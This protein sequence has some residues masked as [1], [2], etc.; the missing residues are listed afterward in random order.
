MKRMLSLLVLS[1]VLICSGCKAETDPEQTLPQTT[2]RQ[3]TPETTEPVLSPGAEAN[4][5]YIQTYASVLETYAQ[6]L[7]ERW[8]QAQCAEAGISILTAY[9]TTGENPLHNLCFAFHDL[10]AD[11]D[12]ELLIAPTFYDGFVDEMV[13][14]MYDMVD[15]AP[16]LLFNGAERI[17][18][19]LCCDE[20]GDWW[21]ANEASGG[22]G[23]SGWFY[24]RYDGAGLSVETSVIYD[25][26]SAP[27]APW[28]LGTDDSWDLNVKEAVEEAAAW[29]MIA[30][31]DAWKTNVHRGFPTQQT[32]F[33]L[34]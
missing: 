6:A 22:A 32:F 14:A 16:R 30:S 17:R 20:N 8:N 15:G 34:K 9:C 10:D 4:S 18:Y 12:S 23:Y 19:Y 7:T 2:V 11:G 27:D 25:A 5:E 33:N 28:F 24:S 3:E 26:D 21:I 13:F 1:V 29:E 31:F